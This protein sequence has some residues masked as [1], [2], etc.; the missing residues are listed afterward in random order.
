MREERREKWRTGRRR[1]WRKLTFSG[2]VLG[3]EGAAGPATAEAGEVEG[4]SSRGRLAMASWVATAQQQGR[5]PV[6]RAVAQHNSRVMGGA[7]A[8]PTSPWRHRSRE[9]RTTQQ[10]GGRTG[11]CT[12]V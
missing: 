4:R 11:D 6:E 3:G 7:A 9:A 10:Q 12:P 8:G 5:R 2:R 1:G